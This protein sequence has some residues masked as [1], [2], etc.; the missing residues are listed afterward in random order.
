MLLCLQ[1][2]YAIAS[3]KSSNIIVLCM[4]E[5]MVCHHIVD[6]SK[7]YFC[8]VVGY[9]LCLIRITHEN[10]HARGIQVTTTLVIVL[11]ASALTF[12]VNQT[13]RLFA[14]PCFVFV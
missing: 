6:H 12:P 7:P 10:E 13:L 9:V 1:F 11:L 2:F 3:T 4:A 8:S 5:V 14:L